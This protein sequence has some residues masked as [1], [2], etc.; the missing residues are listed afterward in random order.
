MGTAV[1][2]IRRTVEGRLRELE[3]IIEELGQLQGILALLED[4]QASGGRSDGT[5][6]QLRA[7]LEKVGIDAEGGSR[8]PIRRSRRGTKPGRDGRAPQGANK[9]RIIEA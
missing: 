3:P 1:E 2:Q 5:S 7:L 9:Q 6:T 8:Q 4:E